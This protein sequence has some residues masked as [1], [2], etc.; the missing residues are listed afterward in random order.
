MS[1]SA[2][3]T[4]PAE[5]KVISDEKVDEGKT[6]NV[7]QENSSGSTQSAATPVQCPIVIPPHVLGQDINEAVESGK[8]VIK[9]RLGVK[10]PYRNL[11]SQIVTHD[12][13]AQE[14]LERS[15]RK[16][17]Y[18]NLENSNILFNMKLANHFPNRIPSP[19][20]ATVTTS[21]VTNQSV[22]LDLLSS[23]DSRIKDNNELLAIL[24]G[25]PEPSNVEQKN[26]SRKNS[27]SDPKHSISPYKFIKLHPELEKEL[28]LKQLEEFTKPKKKKEGPNAAKESVKNKIVK[29]RVKKI[30]ELENNNNID[31]KKPDLKVV[32]KGKPGR[33]RKNISGK[34]EVTVTPKRRRVLKSTNGQVVQATTVADV[35]QITEIP[36]VED[37]PLPLVPPIKDNRYVKKYMN[38]RLTARSDDDLDSSGSNALN[39]TSSV[40]TDNVVHETNIENSSPKIKKTVQRKGVLVV[41]SINH[42]EKMNEN[43]EDVS[44]STATTSNKK[45]TRTMREIDKLLGDEGA[46]NML[47]S[48]EQKRTPG[49]TPN[50]RGI[51]PSTRRKKK[52][53]L[54]KTRLVKNAVLRLSS[55]PPQSLGKTALRGRRESSLPPPPS[56]VPLSSLPVP[57]ASIPVV[58]SHLKSDSSLRKM[59]VDSLQSPVHSSSFAYPEKLSV[60]AEASR[61]IRRHSSSSSYSSRSNSPRRPSIDADRSPLLP[62]SIP[63]SPEKSFGDSDTGGSS[64]PKK[65]FYSPV[66]SQE[67]ASN[68]SEKKQFLNSV[69][70]S[71]TT[72]NE[73]SEKAA[74]ILDAKCREI[75]ASTQDTISKI[76]EDNSPIV[77]KKDIKNLVKNKLNAEV[78][79]TIKKTLMAAKLTKTKRSSLSS[80]VSEIKQKFLEALSKKDSCAASVA[81][82]SASSS[83]ASSVLESGSTLMIGSESSG[84]QL[85]HNADSGQKKR[86]GEEKQRSSVRQ[87]AGAYS[88]KEISL[89]RYEHLV[90]IILTP[91]STK[92]KNAF[93]CQV[94][95]EMTSVLNYLRKDDTCRVVLFTST[96]SA[97]CL[98]V[99]LTA[100][101]HHAPEKRKTAAVELILSMKSFIKSLATFNKPLIAGVHGAAV[102]L[103][104][105]MLPFF[106]MV[107]ASDKATFHTP[108]ARLGQVPEGAAT[109][110]LPHML[111]NAVT[112]ELLFGCRKL[113]ASEA[114]HFGLV[115]RILWPD[116]FQEELIPLIRGIATQSSQSMEATKALLRHNLCSKLDAALISE[117]Q[118]L[119]KHWQSNEC[120]NCF[121]Q[122]LEEETPT[123]QK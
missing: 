43:Q 96:G 71:K 15:M 61:I 104:V 107:F 44:N 39:G 21:T 56:T 116:R 122:Y 67:G 74:H 84:V 18:Q 20:T 106:D 55:S 110:T 13:I 28:A 40:E 19:I 45:K 112:S 24:D 108:Y 60:P 4:L 98:G 79:K 76:M 87:N 33:K 81:A 101:I 29:K 83:S 94:F 1:E 88:Y 120:Q 38:K 72:D 82:M 14:I 62:Q 66:R 3:D 93:N 8:R 99:D 103:G 70:D 42:K 114:L 59:S 68:L 57:P 91:I 117:S 73:L 121:K 75:A 90:Q 52:D 49:N 11:T 31:E 80:P 89:R 65:G 123:F 105:T 27:K 102:G 109:L 6:D 64:P 92:M 69:N 22:E 41:N 34:Q 100:L 37:G 113:T 32:T 26:L 85:S 2:V 58:I 9:P 78:S 30:K 54:L 51:L 118:L 47:Y 46:I 95:K 23:E 17:T 35:S 25:N 77:F 53:L 111:G 7:I 86:D 50:R 63:S 36:I 119:L 5:E 12:E 16:L 115:T 10:V 48:V 97:F